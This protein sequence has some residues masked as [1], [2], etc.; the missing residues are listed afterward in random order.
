[1]AL[2]IKTHG[3]SEL[4]ARLKAMPDDMMVNHIQEANKKAGLIVR[5]DAR[6]RAP[7]HKGPYPASRTN[8][9]AGFAGKLKQSYEAIEQ[10]TKELD[11]PTASLRARRKYAKVIR[12]TVHKMRGTT[13]RQLWNKIREPGTLRKSIILKRL[14]K[15]RKDMTTQEIGLSNKAYYGRWIEY[16]FTHYAKGVGLVHTPPHAFLRPALYENKEQIIATMREAII[17]GLNRVGAK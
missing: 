17:I 9:M 8:T 7:I 13:G 2:T 6:I 3:F 15:K 10:L 14:G 5:N 4:G 12:A 1:M 11:D 16:G